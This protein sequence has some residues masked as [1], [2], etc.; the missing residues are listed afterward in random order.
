MRKLLITF[1][2]ILFPIIAS[3]QLSGSG[4]YADP[5]SGTLVGDAIWSG[6]VYI[7]N[8]IIVDN[9]ILTINPGT[10]VIFLAEAADLRITGTGRLLAAGSSGSMILFTADDNNNGI[11]G[12]A[13]ERWGHITF[14]SMGAAG[15]SQIT[16]CIV[17]YG[18]KSGAGL[19]G[20]GGGLQ[21]NFT[22]VDISYST[23]RY[24]YA[25]WGGAIFV[26]ASKSPPISNCLFL[27]NQSLHAGGGV[28]CWNGSGSSITNCIFDSNQCLEPT[29][30]YYTGGGL[31]GQT[32]TSIK[33]VNCTFVNNTSTRP[34]GQAIL[35]HTSANA[36]VVNC[37][38]WGAPQKQI[39]LYGTTAN[40]LIN[41]AYRGLAHTIGTPVNPV[42]LNA[43]NNAPDGPNFAATD[44]SD[45]SILWA[46]PC[47]DAG[48]DSYT[49]VTIP[50]LDYAGNG[51]TM[52][53]DIGAYE[54]RYCAWKTTAAS[55]DWNTAS[56]WSG[57][58]P[59]SGVSPVVIPSG[60]AN[61]P[62]GSAPAF[63]VGTG[64]FMT[65][66][67]GAKATLGALTNNG[68]VTLKSDATGQSSLIVSSHSGNAVNF[69]LFLTGGGDIDNDNFKWHYISTPVSSL[70]TNVFAPG[71]TYDLAQ[72]VESRPVFSL[73]EGWVAYDG[74]KYSTGTMGGPTFSSLTVGKGYDFWDSNDNTFNFSGQ[75]NTANVPMALGFSGS[76]SLHGFNLL[77]N[78]Y[79][80]GL[81]WDDIA[82]GTY[83]AFPANTSKGVYFT[84]DNTQCT[85]IGGVGIP[86]DVNGI[87]PPMQGFFTKTYATGNTITI[88]AA[89]RV[90]N[91]IHARYKSS[92]G[93]IPLVRLVFMQNG[94]K[95]ETV[96][97]FDQSAKT[98]F[99]YDFD[100]AK[101][102]TN[103]R[104]P[105][106]YSY[107]GN[108]KYAING[109]PFPETPV[110]I[111]LVV[112]VTKTGTHTISATQ[113]D[114]LAGYTLKL[115]DNVTHDTTVLNTVSRFSF[116]ADSGL[117]AGRFVLSVFK[118]GTIGIDDVKPEAKMFNIYTT[119]KTLNIT[120]TGDVQNMVPGTLTVYDLTGKQVLQQEN[121][122]FVNGTPYTV[123]MDTPPGIYI[124][125]VRTAGKQFVQKIVLK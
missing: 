43:T 88:P 68:T 104:I 9:E 14:E 30:A 33:V 49:G 114:G 66:Y 109:I 60:A 87:I 36:R 21:V 98:E 89:A 24:N 17:E 124:V 71:A 56:N 85:Y 4:T 64:T 19:E 35:L 13:G 81:N 61:Y 1:I 31:A 18:Y 37:I 92:A 29:V 52:I 95:D 59:V 110:H 80:S 123:S 79:S 118:G 69:E 117:V 103:M 83:F 62:T 115:S 63:T 10:K 76:A 102:I 116:A 22:N 70:A 93:N 125:K 16:Y 112:N 107:S 113:I 48:V 57:G 47:R 46:S 26:N 73:L 121:I 78:P 99:D 2:S 100:A 97:R 5:W 27:S 75:L 119:F 82:N 74:Y 40:I 90:Q 7:N 8:D 11:Y 23:F 28:Y 91:N 111:P 96:V 84:R 6:T 72:Y 25:Q 101:M 77:G 94:I 44:G 12:E 41:D 106:I 120:L 50:A 67:P 65:L 3:G 86:G 55:T 108:V 122:E 54:V 39:Y 20:Y 32:G 58:I 34:D 38:F 45:W 53:T 15:S 42:L 105:L 51:R